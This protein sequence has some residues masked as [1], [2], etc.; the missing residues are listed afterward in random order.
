MTGWD[1]SQDAG[2][3]NP[4]NASLPHFQST[5]DLQYAHE[6]KKGD[7]AAAHIGVLS[8]LLM[9]LMVALLGMWHDP[10]SHSTCEHLQPQAPIQPPNAGGC[11]KS[12]CCAPTL[13]SWPELHWKASWCTLH[14]LH[15][16]LNQCFSLLGF[17]F[18]SNTRTNIQS[19]FKDLEDDEIFQNQVM[20]V[21]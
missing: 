9:S 15:H 10:S 2:C 11:C 14:F 5:F 16:C 18:C 3:I 4:P 17:S 20:S 21:V 19:I 7:D 6:E 1:V 8:A 12:G 13:S